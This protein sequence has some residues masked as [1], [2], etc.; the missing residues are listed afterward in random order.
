L[1]IRDVSDLET[2][3]ALSILDRRKTHDEIMSSADRKRMVE[4]RA[5]LGFAKVARLPIDLSTVVCLDPPF[6]DIG[7]SLNSAPYFFELGEVTDQG[8]A[9]RY[10]ESLRT[11][12]ITGGAFSQDIPLRRIF[13]SKAQRRYETGGAPVDLLLYYWRQ[14]PYDPVVQQAFSERRT[15]LS[16]GPFSR[17]WLY[18]H[19]ERLLAVV[20]K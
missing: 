15:V 8:L 10:S 12:A 20:P 18:E 4:L 6:P 7:C 5:F 3:D 2:Y 19:P 14:T 1:Q 13:I 16:S 17:I 11:G 9:R